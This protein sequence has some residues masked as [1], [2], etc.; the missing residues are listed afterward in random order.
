MQAT[1]PPTG[2]PGQHENLRVI[3]PIASF[4]IVAGSMLGVG[5]FLFPGKIAYEINSVWVFFMLWG[6]GGIFALAGAVACGELGAMIPR[7]GGDYVFQRASFGP[8]VAF[9]SGTVLFLAIF[10]GSI[11]SMS[12]AVFQYQVGTLLGKD[13]TLPL[14]SGF[15]LS[16]AQICAI[17][18]I[19]AL[20]VLNDAGTKISTRTQV[21]LTLSPIA[22]LT[23]LAVYALAISPSVAPSDIQPKPGAT[24]LTWFGLASGFLFVNFA[25][26]GWIN[27]IYVAGE[28]KDPGKNVP[29][30]M[31][32]ASFGVTALYFL[33]CAAFLTVL[34]LG[35][36]AGLGWTDAGTGMA[37]ALGRPTLAT[38]VLL[39]IAVAILTSLNAT[40]LSSARVAYAMGKDG[41]FWRGAA[42]LHP[43]RRT[44]QNA[45]WL[46]AAISSFLVLTG[47]FDEIVKMTSIAM[48]VTG[49]LTVMSVFVLR[50]RAPEA[51]RPYRAS[52]YPWL[53]ALYVVLSLAAMGMEIWRAFAAGGTNALY[54]LIGIGILFVTLV[55]HLLLV[56]GGRI[57]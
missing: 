40:V 11:A 26:S 21:V 42:R 38:V 1:K 4:A 31:I 45:L 23:A 27:I 48:F 19:I 7:A 39:I 33:L 37:R 5:I 14:S 9:A 50:Y 52:L 10:A 29:R 22:A 56:K 17:V 20:T 3:G 54:P 6:L 44:P 12:V 18:V 16:S 15:P 34:G 36:L 8:S 13:L 41:A 51:P 47:T 35:G 28:V 46:Q 32:S 57:R 53:P 55:G 24:E 25:F 30:S 49:T 43:K 2:P